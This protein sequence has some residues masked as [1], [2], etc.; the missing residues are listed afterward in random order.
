[1][2]IAVASE[3]LEVSPYFG[4][5]SSYMCYTIQRG[6]IVECQN[7]PNP[8]L[9]LNKL[10]SLLHDFDVRTLIVGCIDYDTAHVLCRED[11]EVVAGASG[12]ARDVVQAYL[13]RTLT[14]VDDLCH[15]DEHGDD[16]DRI[17]A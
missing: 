5:C 1:M 13:T 9:P 10:V 17:E 15:I 14:G 2:R 8:G 12:S 11:I 4:Q 6:I 16:F 3:G 7:M